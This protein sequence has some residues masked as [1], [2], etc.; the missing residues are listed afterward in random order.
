MQ[1]VN[2]LK[3]RYEIN[4]EWFVNNFG[5]LNLYYEIKRDYRI[6]YIFNI[7]QNFLKILCCKTMNIHVIFKTTTKIGRSHF[8]L[9]IAVKILQVR[10]WIFKLQVSQKYMQFNGK[11]NIF[12]EFI[13]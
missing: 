5:L 2:I 10:F 1:V 3:K 7:P 8:Y 9:S 11:C 4:Y 12:N 13:Q 6:N